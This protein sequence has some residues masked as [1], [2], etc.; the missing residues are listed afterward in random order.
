M[1]QIGLIGLGTM[2]AALARNLASKGY[3]TAVFNRTFSRTEE[4]IKNHGNDDL[5]PFQELKDFV[6]SLETPRKIILMV[7]A[8]DAVDQTITHLQE[9]IDDGDILIDCGNSNWKDT[10]DRQK[11]FEKMKNQN[12]QSSNQNRK[13]RNINFIG[14]G[15]SGGEEGAL[16]GPSIMPGGDPEVVNQILPILQ[17]ITAKD[18][19]GKPCVT[20]VGLAGAGHFVK[21]VHNGIEYA[22][23]QGIAEIYDIFRKLG[24]DAPHISK[25]FEAL[26]KGQTNSFLTS[27][28]VEIL[29]QKDN[30][31][32]SYLVDQISPKAGA[33]GTGKWTV[34]AAMDLGIAVPNISNA[35]FARVLSSR[36][37]NFEV[38]LAS[39]KTRV[40]THLDQENIIQQLDIDIFKK[41]LEAIFY[42]SY[43]QGLDLIL[44][45]NR[46]YDWKIDILEV[47]R[48][49]QGGCIIRSEMLKT[50]SEDFKQ[51]ESRVNLTAKLTQYHQ[52]L[53]NCFNFL[54]KQDFC[55]PLLSVFNA[56]L[57]Y[58]GALT[59][60]NL[61]TN[62][63]QAQR[64][65]FGAHT[66]Q[67][68]DRE[69]VFTGGWEK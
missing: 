14:C 32:D 46:E 48:I 50:L 6:K 17:D 25:I 35:L 30:L 29:K 42:T 34:E 21:M 24:F 60:D 47:L 5:I 3:K 31:S 65:H 20:N 11:W 8:G 15:V 26:N 19:T 68:I 52:S 39:S 55:L 44:E 66:Y 16:L 22:I 62:L 56:A 43:L 2:G 51:S 13:T 57:D 9:F 40:L 61:P 37:H 36:T 10:L 49:W 12:D 45:A 18:F 63:I 23:M 58:C 54:T 59:M 33:K 38:D 27:I 67:R 4:F 28:S 69:G 41:T 64:D 53:I 7:N 1:Q